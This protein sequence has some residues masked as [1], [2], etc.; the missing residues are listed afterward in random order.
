MAT[1]A[2]PF[3]IIHRQILINH[4]NNNPNSVFFITNTTTSSFRAAQSSRVSF[5]FRPDTNTIRGGFPKLQKQL[6]L[7][8]SVTDSTDEGDPKPTSE[9]RNNSTGA[10]GSGSRRGRQGKGN[11]W[12]WQL[13]NQ[14]REI[15]VLLLKLGIVMFV[16]G[17]EV[18]LPGSEAFVSVPYSEFLSKINSNQVQKVEADGVHIMFKLKGGEL[19]V[20]RVT[21]VVSCRDRSHCRVA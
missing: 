9:N 18:P 15:G 11:E 17:P 1:K 19:G 21:L 8:G 3:T 4:T 16:I 5:E 6:S 7:R 14:A 2:R 10:G 13:I 20:G 12:L